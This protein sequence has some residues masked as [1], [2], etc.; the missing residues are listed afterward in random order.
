[1]KNRLRLN[2]CVTIVIT[3]AL[4]LLGVFVFKSS[5]L[6]IFEAICDVISSV[7]Y[8][9][10]VLFGSPPDELPSVTEYS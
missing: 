2:I 7:K 1:M 10:L 8:Y 9:F 6:R 4:I 5:Y 3:A